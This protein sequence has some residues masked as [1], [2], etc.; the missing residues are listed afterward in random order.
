MPGINEVFTAESIQSFR[1]KSAE[2]V[3]RAEAPMAAS[4][5]G[6]ENKGGKSFEELLCSVQSN[7][8]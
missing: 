1:L 4:R 3:A 8:P 7:T 5:V 6:K 2:W